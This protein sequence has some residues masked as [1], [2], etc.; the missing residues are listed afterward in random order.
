MCSSDT[1]VT[2]IT[3]RQLAVR[4]G[5]TDPEVDVLHLPGT[6]RTAR[7]LELFTERYLAGNLTG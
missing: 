1:S 6:T 3:D 7:Y 5:I 2:Q 4:K